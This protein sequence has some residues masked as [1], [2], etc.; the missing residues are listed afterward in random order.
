MP[1]SHNLMQITQPEAEAMLGR[2]PVIVIAAGSV[3]Q[4]GPHLPFGTDTY[5][6]ELIA[7]RVAEAL[8]ALFV[9]FTPIGVTPFHMS[10]A[11]TITLSIETFM[12]V[13]TDV[14]ES[15][16]RHGVR[17]IVVVNWHE[18]NSPSI[19]VVAD[20][21]QQKHGVRF[22]VANAHY[23]TQ[24]L[25]GQEVGLTHGGLL[26]A[27]AV[28]AYDPSL[29]H[30]ERG[31]NP[32]PRGEAGKMDML[33]RRREVHTVVSDVR[34]IA[35]TGWYGTLEG[36]DVERARAMVDAVIERTVTYVNECFEALDAFE[37]RERP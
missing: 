6:S 25:F 3:E 35:S 29:V 19:N 26:E 4:H 18:G 17:R 14:C 2:N 10:F 23:V 27:L 20:R 13:L 16:I 34:E 9:P 33:R 21:V 7:G 12:G 8:D 1:A 22:V 28:L 24:Q 11:G 32:A 5:A 31:T 15:M 30:L 36:A 37:R